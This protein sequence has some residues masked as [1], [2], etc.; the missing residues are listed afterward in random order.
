MDLISKKPHQ[1]VNHEMGKEQISLLSLICPAGQILLSPERSK[2][3]FEQLEINSAA[4]NNL[5]LQGAGKILR[6]RIL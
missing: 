5:P 2:L 1:E 3:C 6:S 4:Q